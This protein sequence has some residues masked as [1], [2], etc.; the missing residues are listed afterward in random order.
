MF[1]AIMVKPIEIKVEVPKAH[2]KKQQLIMS[3]FSNP[4]IKRIYVACGT[5]YGKAQTLRAVIPTPNGYRLFGD[6]K[7]GDYV[8][9][10]NGKPIEVIGES[11]VKTG[12]D[13]YEVVFQDRSSVVVDGGHLWTTET[14]AC[15]K[16]SARVKSLDDRCMSTSYTPKTLTTLEIRESLYVNVSGKKRP[17]HSIPCVSSPIEMPAKIYPLDP[18]LL[19]VWLAAGGVGTG[20]VNTVTPD[21]VRSFE[22]GGFSVNK[23]KQPAAHYVSGLVPILRKIGVLSKKHVPKDYLEGAVS[24]RLALLQGLME[25]GT[26]CKRGHCTFDNTNENLADAVYQLACSLGI[27]CTRSGRYGKLNGEKKRWCYRV[28]FT[29]DLPVF[30]DNKKLKRLRNVAA[31]AK[32][33]Y[34]VAINPVA[35]EPVKCIAVNSP[36]RLYLTNIECIPT[37]NS[38]SASTCLSQASLVKTNGLWRWIAPIYEQ[39]KIGMS[40][41]KKL[42]PPA[43]H[44]DFKQGA[45][46]IFLPKLDS[47]IQFWHTKHPESL[48]G[49]GSSGNIFDEAAKCPFDAVAAARTTVTFTKGPEGYFSTPFGKNWFFK[50]CMEAKERMEWAIRNDK[51]PE[52]IFLTARTI[53]NPYIDP[54]VVEEA[55]KSLPDRLF[56][57]YYLAEFMD[58]GSVFV[59]F[60]DCIEGPEIDVYGAV[61]HY[62]DPDAEKYSVFLGV[63]WAKKQDYL[64]ATAYAIDPQTSLPKMVGFLRFQGVGYVEALKELYK[65][66][67]KFKD[68]LMLKHD[69][70]GVGEAIDDMLGQLSVP[71]EGVVFTNSSKAEM[72]NKLIMAFETKAIKL[73]NWPEMVRELESF[74][75]TTNALGTARYEAPAGMHDDIVASMMLGYYAAQEYSTEFKLN[76][77]EDLPRQKMSVEK[78]YNDLIDEID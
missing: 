13:C 52:Y 54:E 53:D 69:K 48:E 17:N 7:P 11:P 22:N 44:S 56:R 18:Y 38:L 37:H 27:K 55:R 78:W 4:K 75:V 39:S 36:S 47:E 8:F 60:R 72:I 20:V 57:Q 34:I 26:I 1:P 9:D 58:E 32:R 15:R 46:R 70:T 30:R 66:I 28:N 61:Q 50:E 35:S 12:R 23:D 67:K 42:L 40:Y 64:V 43:P 41:F 68:V 3:A 77:L 73:L 71:F 19:G 31:K 74:T 59:G 2:S 16:A 49:V 29:T 25:E 10:E 33:R 63:D 14:H 62:I 24:Q 51:D 21:A 65:F 5:K 45:M 76:F 6:I